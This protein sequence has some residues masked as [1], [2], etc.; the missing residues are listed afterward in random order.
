[1]LLPER[2]TGAS[3]VFVRFQILCFLP[4]F[5]SV[6]VSS[7][8]YFLLVFPK[9]H[10]LDLFIRHT[11]LISSNLCFHFYILHLMHSLCFTLF[12]M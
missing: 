6:T 5:L 1:M 2:R 3:S 12:V 11:N 10:L 8:L 4:L 9:H 7:G